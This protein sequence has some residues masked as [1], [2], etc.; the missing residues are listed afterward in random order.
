MPEKR[1]GSGVFSCRKRLNGNESADAPEVDHGV[2][3]LGRVG[4]KVGA[5]GF[6]H[7]LVALVFGDQSFLVGM[8]VPVEGVQFF[9][10][11]LWDSRFLV[12]G[13]DDVFGFRAAQKIT[14]DDG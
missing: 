1:R 10:K 5:A 6:V 12:F 7:Y 14:G 4:F 13:N 9:V 3:R 8:V 11:S 2:L